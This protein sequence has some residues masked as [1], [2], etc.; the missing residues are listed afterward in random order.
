MKKM[1]V[2]A[3]LDFAAVIFAAGKVSLNVIDSGAK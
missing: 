3:V 2:F 1:L